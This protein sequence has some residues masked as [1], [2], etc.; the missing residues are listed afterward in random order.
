ML[1]IE[2][3][4]EEKIRAAQEAGEF[5]HLTHHFQRPLLHITRELLLLELDSSSRADGNPA[6]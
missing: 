5:D 4:A 3:I 1:L 6:V 2:R